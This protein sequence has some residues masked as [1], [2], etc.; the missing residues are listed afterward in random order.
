MSL[1]VGISRDACVEKNFGRNNLFLVRMCSLADY[2]MLKYFSRSVFIIEMFAVISDHVRIPVNIGN[3]ALLISLTHP[4]SRLGRSVNMIF[5]VFSSS[6][7]PLLTGLH[8][9]W[10]LAILWTSVSYPASST[11]LLTYYNLCI[12]S[13]TTIFLS[14]FMLNLRGVYLPDSTDMNPGS[15]SRQCPSE[16]RFASS[17]VG[18]LGAPLETRM[19]EVSIESATEIRDTDDEGITMADEADSDKIEISDDPMMVGL[20]RNQA[21]V[22]M[23]EIEVSD[24]HFCG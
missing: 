12:P 3:V 20:C 5:F 7:N 24:S 9:L 18:N 17:I 13:F 22:E 8:P 19:E 16:I 14:R 2:P 21:G 4:F 23:R 10:C 11:R 6:M 1:D 15:S